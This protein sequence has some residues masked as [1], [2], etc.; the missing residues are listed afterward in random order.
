MMVRAWALMKR[1][2]FEAAGPGVDLGFDCVPMADASVICCFDT[3]GLVSVYMPIFSFAAGKAGVADA[4][5]SG[6]AGAEPGYRE[7][8]DAVFGDGC[9]NINLDK[10]VCTWVMST[11]EMPIDVV[12]VAIIHIFAAAES[13]WRSWLQLSFWRSALAAFN[14]VRT[15]LLA[16]VALS[17]SIAA[18]SWVFVASSSVC[19]ADSSVD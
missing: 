16:A 1:T 13:V 5:S 9:D 2:S 8:V 6:E 10:I 19:F 12:A 11:S 18:N 4:T 14:C 15:D 3:H 7:F 17:I